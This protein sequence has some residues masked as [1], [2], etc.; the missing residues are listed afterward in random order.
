MPSPDKALTK[1]SEKRQLRQPQRFPELGVHSFKL[2]QQNKKD[3]TLLNCLE[4]F[5]A[6]SIMYND[7][8]VL[9]DGVTNRRHPDLLY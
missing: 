7:L 2:L 5:I 9:V 6:P 3:D 8:L 1:V 4:S